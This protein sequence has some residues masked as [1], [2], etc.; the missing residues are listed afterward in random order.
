MENCG[1]NATPTRAI[2]SSL[3]SIPSDTFAALTDRYTL[4]R[5]HN[6]KGKEK[7]YRYYAANARY[8]TTSPP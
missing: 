4:R 3:F 1:I 5:Q 2:L 7:K 6:T 8:T